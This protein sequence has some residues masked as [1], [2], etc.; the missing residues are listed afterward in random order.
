MKRQLV[1]NKFVFVSVLHGIV[2]AVFGESRTKT[3]VIMKAILSVVGPPSRSAIFC[4]DSR[5]FKRNTP[6]HGLSQCARQ[7]IVASVAPSAASL[8]T[9]NSEAELFA[10]LKAGQ[11][12]G[13]VHSS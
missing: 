7:R 4:T 1:I 2:W 9:V 13:Q 3:D 5:K 8:A 11:A 10:V 6:I 12:S